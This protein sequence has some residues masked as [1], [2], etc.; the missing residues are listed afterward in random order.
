MAAPRSPRPRRVTL[1]NTPE[2]FSRLSLAQYDA[3]RRYHREG[4]DA[5]LEGRHG[6]DLS[7]QDLEACLALQRVNLQGTEGATFD[8]PASRAALV[9]EESRVLLMRAAPPSVSTPMSPGGGGATGASSS[10]EEE[11]EEEAADGEEWDFV[12]E[13]DHPLPGR[14][15]LTPMMMAM[16]PSPSPAVVEAAASS[17][18]SSGEEDLQGVVVKPAQLCVEPPLLGYLHLQFCVSEATPLLCVLNMQLVPDVMGKGLG[19]FAL[20]LVELMARQLG[21]E[22]VMIYL[23]EGKVTTMRLS[24][25]KTITEK[26]TTSSSSS[27]SALSSPGRG[28]AK[29][30][31]GAGPT[32]DEFELIARPGPVLLQQGRPVSVR[33]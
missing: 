4:I 12:E 15:A 21:M 1:C 13:F 23:K 8:E 33:C 19:K 28:H 30:A 24:K 17:S 9:H 20:Q 32:A 3:F 25:Q 31:D 2:Y 10:E 7:A 29:A 22:L 27:S 11:E 16:R 5:L 18:S 6:A 14:T 26:S